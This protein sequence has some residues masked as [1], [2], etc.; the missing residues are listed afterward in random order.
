M[1]PTSRTLA[2]A[3]TA[4]SLLALAVG[5]GVGYA[6]G[7]LPKNSVGS[8]QV[9]NGAIKG[10]DLK[11]DAVTGAKVKDGSLVGADLSANSVTGA[12]IDESSLT[13]PS[14]PGT[15][16][17]VGTAF[18]PLQSSEGYSQAGLAS[19]SRVTDGYLVAS[20]PIAADVL[21]TSVTFYVLDNGPGS[22][23]VR[24]NSVD[25]A[26]LG[27]LPSTE[28]TSTGQAMAAQALTVTPAV[29]AG[30][31]LELQVHLPAGGSYAILGA[32]VTYE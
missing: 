22:V 21:A 24:S 20:V 16:T 4:A 28:A 23:A 13:M 10:V 15:I 1:R 29:L 7:S 17:L 5:G 14:K 27:F 18:T 12:Q 26:G 11:N 2:V 19:R 32:K 25:V 3:V 9:K 6:A 30:S 8:A 31:M